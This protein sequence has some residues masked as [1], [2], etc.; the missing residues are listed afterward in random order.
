MHVMHVYVCIFPTDTTD[1]VTMSSPPW[2]VTLSKCDMISTDATD[3]LPMINQHWDKR[4]SK[5]QSHTT[6]TTDTI[7]VPSP[8]LCLYYI[9]HHTI[10]TDE[11]WYNAYVGNERE[12]GKKE[13]TRKEETVQT[14]LIVSVVMKKTTRE[15][16]EERERICDE[17]NIRR[18]M[19][20]SELTNSQRARN[21][22]T[23]GINQLTKRN[24]ET[25]T[26]HFVAL[27]IHRGESAA[28]VFPT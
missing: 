12:S 24:K 4:L 3:E 22:N 14:T 17:E 20:S 28:T 6:D 11:K 25:I 27:T 13:E 2:D 23:H 16:H 21:E 18:G 15:K 8:L 10:T 1:D 7:I 26:S 9:H 5:Q 19:C